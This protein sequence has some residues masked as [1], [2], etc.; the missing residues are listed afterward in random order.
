MGCFASS[1]TPETQTSKALGK[2]LANKRQ[3]EAQVKKLLLLGAGGS[4][5]STFFKGRLVI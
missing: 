5:K 3:A 4:G 2:S 1:A